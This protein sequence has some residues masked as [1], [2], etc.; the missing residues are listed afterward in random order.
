MAYHLKVRGE[1]KLSLSF[2]IRR[3]CDA[4]AEAARCGQLVGDGGICS[5]EKNSEKSGITQVRL[6]P[7]KPMSDKISLVENC[8]SYEIIAYLCQSRWHNCFHRL[9]PLHFNFCL[10]TL[11]N[12]VSG[13]DASGS[14]FFAL[15]MVTTDPRSTCIGLRPSNV[16]NTG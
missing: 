14:V 15:R 10:T 1:W 4:H 8:V 12:E 2:Q 11:K 16:R 6:N 9:L 3:S 7:A 5:R 13:S